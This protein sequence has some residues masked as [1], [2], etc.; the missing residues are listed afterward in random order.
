MNA[1]NFGAGSPVLNGVTF[2]QSALTPGN[3]LTATTSSYF[4]NVGGGGTFTGDNSFSG[5]ATAP[6]NGLSPAYK[7]LIGTGWQTTAAGSPLQLELLGLTSGVVYQVQFWSNDSATAN[8]GTVTVTG[9]DPSHVAVGSSVTLDLNSTNAVGGVGQF[10]VGTFT[11]DSAF[12]N[13]NF[14]TGRV[15]RRF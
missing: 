1:F 7:T 5:G 4:V 13:F 9:A 6:F 3:V 15:L 11:A 8:A 2:A 10:V 14:T 12:Q